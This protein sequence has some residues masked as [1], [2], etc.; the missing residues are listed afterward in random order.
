M[1][2]KYPRIYPILKF[3]GRLSKS[4]VL[5]F[6]N[7][8]SIDELSQHEL[9]DIGEKITKEIIIPKIRG[10]SKVNR[11]D[12]LRDVRGVPFDLIATYMKEIWLIETKTGKSGFGGIQATQKKRMKKILEL[13]TKEGIKGRPLLVQIELET[14][15]Y[16]VKDFPIKYTEKGLAPTFQRIVESI[17][18][19]RRNES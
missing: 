5:R 17:L 10:I 2:S 14:G 16:R 3:K 13:L 4:E 6:T 7:G 11:L 1:Y 15:N 9:G 8:R 18:N 19:Y 12:E